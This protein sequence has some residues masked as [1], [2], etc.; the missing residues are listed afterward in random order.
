LLA[1]RFLAVC[2][3][4][5]QLLDVLVTIGGVNL[6]NAQVMDILKKVV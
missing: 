4:A 3:P 1:S 5:K 6:T 2:R